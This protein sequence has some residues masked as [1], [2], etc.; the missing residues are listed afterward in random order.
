MPCTAE[1]GEGA[2]EDPLPVAAVILAGL[3]RGRWVYRSVMACRQYI[4]TC[5]DRLA[6]PSPET[7]VRTMLD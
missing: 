1:G 3:S 2:L 4:G 6:A 5:T 7:N